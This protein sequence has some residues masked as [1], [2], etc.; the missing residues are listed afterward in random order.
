MRLNSWPV[1]KACRLDRH[2]CSTMHRQGRPVCSGADSFKARPQRARSTRARR[3][4]RHWLRSFGH[5]GCQGGAWLQTSTGPGS[6]RRMAAGLRC[7]IWCSGKFSSTAGN[8]PSRRPTRSAGAFSMW[9]SAPVCHCRTIHPA[10]SCAASISLSR[11]CARHSNAFGDWACE[12]SRR[13][14]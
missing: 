3:G 5:N 6:P 13:S 4:N 9:A 7:T 14:R 11:C 1:K 12:M 8:P 2:A 10:P